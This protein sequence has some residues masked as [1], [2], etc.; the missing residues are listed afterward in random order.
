MKELKFRA[1]DKITNAFIYSDQIAGGMW[2]YFK[3]LEDRGIRH[4]ESQQFTGLLDKLGREI[5]EGDIL[6]PAPYL[7]EQDN[8]EVFWDNDLGGFAT[9]DGLHIKDECYE[10]IGNIYENPEL[11]GEGNETKD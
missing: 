1:Y 3:T 10:V 6:S 11:L 4:F 9:S 5:Y 2:R 7:D 8:Q